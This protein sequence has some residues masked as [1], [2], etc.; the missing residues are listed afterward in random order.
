MRTEIQARK[1]HAGFPQ[2]GAEALL[3][4]VQL[5]ERE[6][7]ASHAGLVADDHQRVAAGMQLAQSLGC[8]GEEAQPSG[9]IQVAAIDHDRAVAVEDDG[10]GEA[11][12]GHAS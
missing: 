10:A 9:V 8:A 1:R 7:A 12:C 2:H 5:L 11:R 4:G 6:Q 3:H